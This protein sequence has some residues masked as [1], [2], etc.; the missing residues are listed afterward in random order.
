MHRATAHWHLPD[1][2]RFLH[3]S[4]LLNA[5]DMLVLAD[6]RCCGVIMAYMSMILLRNRSD[7]CVDHQYSMGRGRCLDALFL[8]TVTPC[9]GVR[10]LG[11]VAYL[12]PDKAYREPERAN[13]VHLVTAEQRC[14]L[15]RRA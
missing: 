11:F 15:A 2:S 4:S 9:Q 8:I 5:L 6:W 10:P 13:D 1:S 7:E 14:L 12:E 3:R